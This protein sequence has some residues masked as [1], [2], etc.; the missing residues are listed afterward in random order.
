MMS[1]T[2][3]WIKEQFEKESK[4]NPITDVWSLKRTIEKM[5]DRIKQLETDVAWLQKGQ[6]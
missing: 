5:D 6:Q 3:A 4:A 1:A 2:Q